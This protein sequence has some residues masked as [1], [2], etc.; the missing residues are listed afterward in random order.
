MRDETCRPGQVALD[1]VLVFVAGIVVLGGLIA[2]EGPRLQVYPPPTSSERVR[3]YLVGAPA[4]AAGIGII[5]FVV[6]RG[7]RR[8]WRSLRR[9]TGVL[10]VSVIFPALIGAFNAA[11]FGANAAALATL[12]IGVGF[13]GV[14]AV[15][16]RRS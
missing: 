7:G 1:L 6:L 11:Y 16:L 14:G 5:A 15:L 8:G 4:L 9:L 10:A 3:S 13:V 2:L 12:A